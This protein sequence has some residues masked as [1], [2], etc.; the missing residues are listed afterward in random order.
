METKVDK[1]TKEY[2]DSV[3]LAETLEQADSPE[4]VAAEPVEGV[5]IKDAYANVENN[6]KFRRCMHCWTELPPNEDG[7]PKFRKVPEPCD[8]CIWRNA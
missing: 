7:S 2:K 3:V 6:P 8:K 1:R 4:V 5:Y